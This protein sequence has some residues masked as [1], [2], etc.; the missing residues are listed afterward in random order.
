MTRINILPPKALT[1]QHLFAEYREIG[2]ILTL[3]KK[4]IDDKKPLN[5][6]PLYFTLNTGHVKFFYNK[7]K[8]IYNRIQYLKS[9]LDLRGFNVFE[10]N[11]LPFDNN[12]WSPTNKDYDIIKERIVEKVSNQ[13]KKLRYYKKDIELSEYLT[14]L[15]A[16]K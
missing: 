2:R 11:Q 1:D 4:R 3:V 13:S 6:V 12:D 16:S 14:L 9:E 7:T 5:D 15:S 10:Y 8:Y